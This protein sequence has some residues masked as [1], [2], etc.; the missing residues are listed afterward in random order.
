MSQ[1]PLVDL[2]AQHTQIR[3]ELQTELARVMENTSFILGEDVRKFEV[4]FA[5]FVGVT[6]C[7]GVANGTDALELALRACKIEPGDEVIVPANT[8]IA[9][10]LAVARAGAKPVLVD[11]DARHQLIDPD[12][13]GDRISSRTRAIM[14]VHLFGQVAPMEDVQTIAEKHSLKVIEDAAQAHG[15]KRHGRAAGTFG[16]AA[17]FSFY[18]GKNL[19]AYGDAGGVVT[20][21]DETAKHLRALRNY[22][23]EIKYHHPELGFNSRLDT[24]QAVVLRLK[25]RLLDQWN[26]RRRAAALYYDA[27]LADLPNVERPN[28]LQGNEHVWHLYVVR[29]AN[30][31]EVLKSLNAAGIGAGVHYPIPIHL[32]GAFRHLGHTKGNFPNTE[33]AANEILSLPMYAE[34]TRAQQEEVVKSLESAV[35]AANG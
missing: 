16:V 11:C 14:P 26:A 18:P 1:I 12:A 34:I 32:Q 25:L 29:V 15:A 13:I 10:A 21:S 23:S 5:R 24:L 9:T 20:N 4:E 28:T 3:D 8:F 6:H 22:G 35:R 17:G 31:D 30:R 2:K 19:G 27:L 7:V 33:A